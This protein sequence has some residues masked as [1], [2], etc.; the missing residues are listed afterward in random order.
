MNG[1]EGI[2]V[3]PDGKKVYVTGSGYTDVIDTETNKVIA[4][5]ETS[6]SSGVVV[7]PDG[8]KV[9][10]TDNGN[11]NVFVVNT[12]SNAVIAKVPVGSLPYGIAVTPDGK[13]V[14]VV[15][16]MDAVSVIDTASNNVTATVNV[17]N[18]PVA[19][20]QFIGEKPVLEPL[21]PVS[22]LSDNVTIGT[23][24]EQKP[25]QMQSSDTSGKGSTKASGFEIAS[26]ISCLLGALLYKQDKKR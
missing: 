8:T 6:E 16:S 26:V 19:F 7:S 22:N 1:I 24:V 4:T 12:A 3:S 5:V 25:E 15:N 10:V 11:G 13:K 9:Y 17:G 2:A 18:N 20:G 21:P 14:Y 23:N